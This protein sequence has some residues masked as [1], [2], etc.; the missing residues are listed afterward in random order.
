MNNKPT[1][2]ECGIC[3]NCALQINGGSGF[4]TCAEAHAAFEIEHVG[5]GAIRYSPRRQ[6]AAA[7]PIAWLNDAC[8]ARGVVDGEAGSDDAGPGYIP[9]YREP[10]PLNDAERAELQEYRAA[11]RSDREMLKRLA[12]IL[13]GSDAQ[14]E[15][16]VLTV[17]AQ[18]YVDRCKKLSAELQECRQPTASFRGDE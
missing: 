11:Q 7:L 17:T 4:K 10:L 3:A 15:I 16:S 2:N 6:P 5:T 12:V 1:D 8:L 14:G 18:S 9:V 13:S